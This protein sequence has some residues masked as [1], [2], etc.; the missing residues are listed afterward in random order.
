MKMRISWAVLFLSVSASAGTI[1]CLSPNGI[2]GYSSWSSDGGPA[3]MPGME[4]GTETWTYRGRVYGT[5]QHLYLEEDQVTGRPG[6][7]IEKSKH[8][9]DDSHAADEPTG[10]ISYWI[11]A[12]THGGVRKLVC[13]HTY[14]TIPIP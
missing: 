6:H 1:E 4:I 2:W 13:K 11:H 3:P 10:W 12:K 7:F 8:I 5:V 9:I 14:P